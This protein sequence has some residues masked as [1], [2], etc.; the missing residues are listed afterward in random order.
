MSI[1]EKLQTIAE[2]QQSVY[3]AGYQ[4]G[5]AE[6]GNSEAERN[7]FWEQFQ[8]RWQNDYFWAFANNAFSDETYNP[9]KPIVCG[10]NGTQSSSCMFRESRLITDTKVDI[11]VSTQNMNYCFLGASKLETIRKLIIFET[12][13]CTGAFN[14]CKALKNIIFDGVIGQD[15]S[16]KDSN[17]LTHDSLMNIIEHL[18]TTTTTKTLTL[19]ADSKAILTDVEKAIATQKGWTIA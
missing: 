15:I 4:K 9:I 14:S 6:G 17:L 2:N 18:S 3:N 7:A 1:A 5:K 10:A 16:F 13:L 12:T 8:N 11:Q 19:H